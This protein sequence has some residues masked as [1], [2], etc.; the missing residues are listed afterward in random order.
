MAN[1]SIDVTESVLFYLGLA[2]YIS[3]RGTCPTKQVGAVIVDEGLN[4][5]LS[6]GLNDAPRGLQRCGAECQ[7]RTIGENSKSCQAIHAEMNA[8][9][10]AARVGIP[11]TKATMYVTISPC[12]NCARAIIQSG[13][14]AVYASSMSPYE[15]AL[16]ILKQA[17]VKTAI[18][19][20]VSLPRV[21]MPPWMTSEDTSG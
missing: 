21:I 14:S 20:G 2:K 9:L 18:V 10:N 7:N 13:I 15:K 16:D 19:S 11:I 1:E 6:T 12:L 5:V 17:G 3:T 8:I 4:I